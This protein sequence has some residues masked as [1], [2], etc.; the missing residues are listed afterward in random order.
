MKAFSKLLRELTT[1]SPVKWN[2]HFID[3]LNGTF[4]VTV[5][6][7]QTRY[8]KDF[9]NEKSIVFTINNYE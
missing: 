9:F 7:D 5:Y 8:L 4:Y 3:S 6:K 1:L 2:G